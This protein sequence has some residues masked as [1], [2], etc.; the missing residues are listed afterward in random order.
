MERRLIMFDKQWIFDIEQHKAYLE[1]CEAN[2]KKPCFEEEIMFKRGISGK[3]G[4]IEDLSDPY[5]LPD[6]DRAVDR[7]LSAVEE[8]QKIAVF[9]DYDADGVTASAVLYHFLQNLMGAEVVCYIP[10]RVLEGYGM[11][12]GAIDK[13]ADM[14]VSLIITVDNGIVAFDE[15]EHAKALG[16]D[17]V[18]TDHHKCSD[19]LPECCAVV[20]PCILKENTPASHLCGAGVAYALVRA[21][22]EAIGLYEE[23]ACYLPIV[24]I[25]T[26]G[27]VVPL[28]GDNRII[29]KY[30]MEHFSEYP[31][32]GLQSLMKL[33]SEGRS[34]P[35]N[36][37]SV[38]ISFQIV[39]KIN[40][41][42]RI[43]NAKR[44]FDL[45]ISE[46]LQE[47]QMLAGELMAENLKRKETENEIA[48]A[49]MSEEHLISMPEDAVVVAVG[50]G[51]HHG[52][53]GIVAS[54]LVEKY[55][56]PAFV[57]SSEDNM[58][59]GSA[60]SIEG[61]N[62]HA[63]LT[64]CAELTE[65][66]GGHEMAAGLCVPKD[67]LRKL[68][69]A[70]NKFAKENKEALSKPPSIEIDA[71]AEPFEITVETARKIAE[72]EPFGTGNPEPLVCIRNLKLN[73]CSKVGE[74]GKHL[75]MSFLSA[76]PEANNIVIDAIA[77]SKGSFETMVK[78][79]RG[80]CSIIGRLQINTWQGQERVS[81]IVSDIFDD[82]YNVDKIVNCV[83]NSRYI[84]SN[85]F[86][87]ER[88]TLTVMYKQLLSCGESFKF[89]EIY[90]VR[91]IMR[92]AGISC[93]WYLIRAGLDIF[94]ELGLI[95]RKDR[96]NFI[97]QKDAKKVE[98]TD[99]VLYR[100]IQVGE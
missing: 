59:K 4:E 61:F 76:A 89:T 40:A 78:Q 86:A 80:V 91:E 28:D 42:G 6:M 3:A 92:Q 35:P 47:A 71:V 73:Y 55:G 23:T 14:D 31:W 48:E 95:I 45:L 85:S 64:S 87:M 10:D 56:K 11:S 17:I 37:T 5:I 1:K 77:F 2:G 53:I 65:R 29:V 38:F 57:F 49:A 90:R 39:P 84:T 21:L 97:I 15:I 36:I 27:D 13:I 7:I 51:W 52:V 46:D 62:I 81:V 79:V 18:V 93:T 43:G 82:D 74:N 25:G 32:P 94:T 19:K 99:S 98:L 30:G 9:G 22:A 24:M 44:A 68:V 26:L 33:I 88:K 16:I 100:A 20:N 75:K 58:A 72:L 67:N 69:E 34:T 96:N 60:R 54:K 66:F 70:M 50:E 63:A 8:G 41:A 83:Y 12:I